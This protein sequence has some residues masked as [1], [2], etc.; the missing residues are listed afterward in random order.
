MSQHVLLI[1]KESDS[2]DESFAELLLLAGITPYIVNAE[3]LLNGAVAMPNADVVMMEYNWQN[4]L[5]LRGYQLTRN[6]SKDIVVI[7]VGKERP[8][9]ALT[10]IRQIGHFNVYPFAADL[11]CAL[12]KYLVN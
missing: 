12:Q 9:A 4:I 8:L 11:I 3:Q 1:I 5:A 6:F 10:G 2:F 7:S